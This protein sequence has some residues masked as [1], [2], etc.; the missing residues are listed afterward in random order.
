MMNLTRAI[1]L[2]ALLSGALVGAQAWAAEPAQPARGLT[3]KK[4][5]PLGE[6][7]NTSQSVSI[8]GNNRNVA[9][10]DRRDADK[11]VVSVNGVPGKE[12]PWVVAASLTFSA[13]STTPAYLVVVKE[14]MFA[15]VGSTP[16]K[17]YDEILKNTIFAIPGT[18]QFAFFARPKQ[19]ERPLVHI[20][21]EDGPQ[22]DEVGNLVFTADGKRWAYAVRDRSKM[23][24]IIDKKPS[25]EYDAVIGDSFVWSPDGT[26]HAFLAR[27]GEGESAIWHVVVDGKSM[28]Q[29]KVLGRPFFSPDS[30]RVAFAAGTDKQVQL[31]I[32][33][34]AVHTPFDQILGDTIRFSPDSKRVAYL[35]GRAAVG[36]RKASLF[37]VVDGE[38]QKGFDRIVSGSFIFSPDSKHHAY[39][40]ITV[41]DADANKLQLV[42]MIDG[43]GGRSYDD[44]RLAQ[45]SPDSRKFAFL[46]KRGDRVYA[47]EDNIEGAGYEAVSNLQ[48]S[49]DGKHLL[50]VA[51]R[52]N[53]WYVVVDGIVGP[54]YDGIVET[55][56]CFSPDG[57]HVAYEARRSVPAAREGEAPRLVPFFVVDKFESPTHDGSLRGSRLIWD[58]NN[59]L[60]AL[61][62]KTGEDKNKAQLVMWEMG[63][64]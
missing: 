14:G 55:T 64:E 4:Q 48:F 9:V 42:A 27:N 22:F 40:G 53:K 58:D 15:V 1:G 11:F 3:I 57:N 18:S 50:Y 30:K 2:V 20:A 61:V 47:V 39:V 7:P 54:E 25:A 13:D 41:D 8:S 28:Y 34:Q 60:R 21:G 37:Y 56:I 33:G 62:L 63:L 51:S 17:T 36:E 12:Y 26:R 59:T 6:L 10:L 16:T 31:V 38:E 5:T 19:R 49:P 46:A 45:W 24:F 43:R 44:I 29:A 35:A 23:F 32:D 52:N